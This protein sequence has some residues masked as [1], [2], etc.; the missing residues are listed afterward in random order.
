V[1]IG[2]EE[3]RILQPSA[4]ASAP[5]G[6]FVVADAPN[7]VERV[8]IFRPDGVKVGGFGLPGRNAA[9]ITLGSLV[10]NGV[11]SLAYTGRSILINQPETGALITEYTLSGRGTRTIGSLRRTGHEGDRDVHLALN[12]GIPLADPTGGFY[13][14]FQAGVPMFRK[15]AR[16]G[17]VVF[18]RHIEGAEIDA[19]VQAVP[20]HWPRR[21]V[22]PGGELRWFLRACAR[23]PSI[24]TVTSGSRSPCPSPT[25]TTLPGTRH[26]SSSSAAAPASWRPPACS[27][28]TVRG[29]S[30]RP[31]VS[32][33]G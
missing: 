3:G 29:C 20:T 26:A 30:S 31:A 14:V 17:R 5:D 1:Q 21:A 27:S 13:F 6:S 18:E 9:R 16:D 8:Q 10:L 12:V 19:I 7:A 23:Q 25:C 22:N 2:F 24:R 4:F 33:S 15:Y 32:S 11:G 28:P